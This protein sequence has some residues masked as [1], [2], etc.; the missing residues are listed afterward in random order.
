M[1]ILHDQYAAALRGVA[2]LTGRQVEVLFRGAVTGKPDKDTAALLRDLPDA[3]DQFGIMSGE[4]A[5]AYYDEARSAAGNPIDFLATPS[6]LA[7][8]EQVAASIRW[9]VGPMWTS[10]DYD[11]ALGRLTAAME[12]LT[13]QPGRRTI[14]DSAV[15]DR[16]KVGWA[17]T[18]EPG[19][20]GFCLMLASRGAV[21]RSKSTASIA[22]NGP[23]V[24]QSYH[25]NCRCTPAP[26]FEGEP[27]PEINQRLQQIWR[28]N[29]AGTT[30]AEIQQ[31]LVDAFQSWH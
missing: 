23:R 19:A 5:A 30:D 24:G 14:I 26:V 8:A 11:A 13:L 7:T 28:D 22:G 3:V 1:P 20:C 18:P 15:S 2:V 17:R 6:G 29:K 12:R 25:D 21:Y 4:I 16:I 27:V 31:A 10:D 9:A